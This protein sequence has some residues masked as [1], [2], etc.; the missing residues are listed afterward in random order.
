MRL[1]RAALLL[2]LLLLPL[3]LLPPA[4]AAAVLPEGVD[5]Y[6]VL[7]APRGAGQRELKAA[8]RRALNVLGRRASRG[9]HGQ[10]TEDKDYA[11]LVAVRQ[12]F[13]LLSDAQ[14]KAAWDAAHPPA[15]GG[16]DGG[17]AAA[18]AEAG[19][20]MEEDEDDL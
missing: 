5:P 11:Q 3:L 13:E 17:A 2:L 4:A 9:G 20:R 7:R 19:W 6:A 14:R 8:Y 10:V 18:A 1:L 12:A 15:A 16:S